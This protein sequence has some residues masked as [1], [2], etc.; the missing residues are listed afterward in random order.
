[1]FALQVQGDSLIGDHILDGD[2]IIV[3]NQG[4]AEN[5]DVVAALIDD[6]ATV[7]RLDSKSSPAMLVPS[8]PNYDPI[9]V[10]EE[11]VRILGTVVGLIRTWNGTKRTR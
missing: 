5:G 4:H 10:I 2:T 9:N 6:E 11:E 7:K 8:N 1:M 3:K